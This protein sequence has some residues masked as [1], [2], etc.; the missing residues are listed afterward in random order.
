M[1]KEY[2]NPNV[3]VLV[4]DET[5]CIRTSGMGLLNDDLVDYNAIWGENA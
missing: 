3:T 4:V 5:D 2:M 1:K